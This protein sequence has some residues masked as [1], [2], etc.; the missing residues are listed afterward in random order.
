[1]GVGS[2]TNWWLEQRGQRLMEWQDLD[3]VV[4]P[5]EGLIPDSLYTLRMEADSV[6]VDNALSFLCGLPGKRG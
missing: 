6:L 2:N 1:M 3:E 5:L 4:I